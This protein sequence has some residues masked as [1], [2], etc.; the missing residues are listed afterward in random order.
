LIGYLTISTNIS[1]YGDTLS[2]TVLF[3]FLQHSAS[4][5]APTTAVQNS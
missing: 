2:T 3:A 4:M 5:H 1:C